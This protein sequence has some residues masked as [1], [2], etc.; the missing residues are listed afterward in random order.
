MNPEIFWQ[1]KKC[2]E[3]IRDACLALGTPVSGGN[4]SF[5]NQSPKGAVDP[6]PTIG[7]V[8]LID[9]WKPVTSNFKSEDDVILFLGDTKEDLGGSEFLK[10]LF[11]VKSGLPPRLNLESEKKLISLLTTLAKKGLLRSAHDCSEGGLAV[12]LAEACIL[13]EGAE[14]GAK[15]ECPTSG[16]SNEA[17]LFGETQS[18]AVI[19]VSP[20]NLK[21]VQDVIESMAYPT[22]VVGKVGGKAL[23]INAL[24]KIPVEILKHTWRN[25]IGRRMEA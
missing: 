15:I 9:G 6:T 1:F 4:V 10:T 11:G 24:I 20:K 16:V 3:G 17:F 21:A 8:G 25:A 12:A 2:A 18:R 14:V 5:Y 22:R 19:S 7:M 23:E 13:Q